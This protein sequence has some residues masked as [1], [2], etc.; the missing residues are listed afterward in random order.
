MNNNDTNEQDID[1]I[2]APDLVVKKQQPIRATINILFEHIRNHEWTE[3]KKI[4][5]FD[6]SVDVNIRDN[7]TNYL[8]S[9]A[10]RF[11]RLDIVSMILSLDT[12]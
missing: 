2:S 9:Y 4:M 8:L 10:V 1:K 12:F 6:K 11:N 5:E 7:Q 3:F